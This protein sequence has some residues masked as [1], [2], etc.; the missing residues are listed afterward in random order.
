MPSYLIHS[1]RVSRPGCVRKMF[2]YDPTCLLRFLL[3]N[4]CSSG[5]P[6]VRM[7][8]E[9]R[10]ARQSKILVIV[11]IQPQLDISVDSRPLVV[12]LESLRKSACRPPTAATGPQFV[13]GQRDHKENEPDDKEGSK[14]R[15]EDN[16]DGPHDA[17]VLVILWQKGMVETNYGGY[18]GSDDDG[19]AGCG[20]PDDDF[21]MGRRGRNR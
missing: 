11:Q 6:R 13:P 2:F 21:A 19:I 5:Y 10:T 1:Y 17:V 15:G 3:L 16:G 14:K 20:Q 8:E 4:T 7:L 9:R 12:L 18:H